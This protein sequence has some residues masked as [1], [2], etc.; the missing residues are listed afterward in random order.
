MNQPQLTH[1]ANGAL[2]LGHPM[3]FLIIAVLALF[4]PNGLYLYFAI[5]QPESNQAAMRNPIALAF[6]IEAMMLLGLFLWQVR[7]ITCSWAQV[8]LYLL[9][10]FVGSLAFSL[11]L[12]LYRQSKCAASKNAG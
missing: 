7:R 2:S 11:P 12:F 4:G 9:L 8:G 1:P 3:V 6:M 10:S 5:T